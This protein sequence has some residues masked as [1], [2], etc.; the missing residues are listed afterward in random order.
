M[1][2]GLDWI[3]LCRALAFKGA[4]FGT[5]ILL[6]YKCRPHAWRVEVLFVKLVPIH[7]SSLN[8]T[9]T[10]AKI[11]Q[12]TMLWHVVT[13]TEIRAQSS[14]LPFTGFPL[15]KNI[16]QGKNRPKD[17]QR[18]KENHLPIPIPLVKQ[19]RTSDQEKQHREK[20]AQSIDSQCD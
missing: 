6:S 7:S 14:S 4:A 11:R 10:K 16:C 12:K 20:A 1:G 19:G 9:T 15:D 8:D 2:A 5:V 3:F 18:P 17:Q 13:W